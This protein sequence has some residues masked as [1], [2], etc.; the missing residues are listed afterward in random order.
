MFA[1]YCSTMGV[2][3]W[4]VMLTFWSVL[5]AVVVWGVTRLFPGRMPTDPPPGG[6]VGR[7]VD[8][9]REPVATTRGHPSDADA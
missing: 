6:G 2:A 5:I 8:V 4:L 3:G 9:P 1:S 7:V